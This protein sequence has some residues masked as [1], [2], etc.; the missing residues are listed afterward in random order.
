MIGLIDSFY[1]SI[2]TGITNCHPYT[3]DGSS[4]DDRGG[5]QNWSKGICA[6][7]EGDTS[8]SSAKTAYWPPSTASAYE[9]VEDLS[10][11]LTSGRLTK[12]NKAL[13]AGHVKTAMKEGDV[14]KAVR[15]A[16]ELVISTPEFHVTNH[17][18]KQENIRESFGYA[19]EPR[20]NYKAVVVLMMIGGLDSFN[21]L[22]PKGQCAGDDQ[23]Q[24]YQN[25]RGSKHAIPLS[26]LES[27]YANGSNQTC[28]EYGVNVDFDI[29]SELYD[30]KELLFLA[31]CGVLSKPMTRYDWS[32][33]SSFQPFAHNI[34]Q[35]RFAC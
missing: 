11:L 14:G 19:E 1:S 10:L 7:E 8:L 26:R 12:E 23:H 28:L 31:N 35:V 34:M 6:L 17:I 25:L 32:K 24:N 9:I 29:L 16:Q 30:S 13:I 33:E 4:G 27:I 18:R 2:K 15:I 20:S 5:N 3:F 21:L 22:L